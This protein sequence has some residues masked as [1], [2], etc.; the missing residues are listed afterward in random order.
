M[1]KEQYLTLGI[2]AAIALIICV[3][4]HQFAAWRDRENKRREQ[5][6]AYL[7]GA[8][9]ALASASHHPRIHEIAKEVEQAIADIQF[10]GTKAQIEL[11]RI[12]V[13]ALVTK[14]N[15]DL[16]P[17]LSSLRDE[18][19]KEIGREAYEGDI[20]WIKISEKK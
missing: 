6:V 14:Q 12:F 19:R 1:T 17:L 3:G 15:A 4:S 13:H 18:L 10:F 16:D 8:F 5:R 2:P 7:I 20:V 9:R 11:A